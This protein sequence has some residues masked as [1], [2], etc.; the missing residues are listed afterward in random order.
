MNGE[1]FGEKEL[2]WF[3]R[4]REAMGGEDEIHDY[5]TFKAQ[6]EEPTK[7]FGQ[8][9][10]NLATGTQ[11]GSYPKAN[12]LTPTPVSEQ[13]RLWTYEEVREFNQPAFKRCYLSE[14]KDLLDNGYPEWVSSR[15]QEIGKQFCFHTNDLLRYVHFIL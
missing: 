3:D 15:I 10:S 11:G 2:M 4:L 13:M 12:H 8:F 5:P 6:I 9:L 7:V 1:P 14:K